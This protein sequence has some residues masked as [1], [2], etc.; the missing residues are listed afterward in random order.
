MPLYVQVHS[1]R[2]CSATTSQILQSKVAAS[3]RQESVKA[4]FIQKC[5]NQQAQLF[6]TAS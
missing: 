3:L 5:A 1:V 6:Q 4:L 2:Y